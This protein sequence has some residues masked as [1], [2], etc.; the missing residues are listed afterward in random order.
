M[1]ALGV[2]AQRNEPVT[3]KA[4]EVDLAQFRMKVVGESNYQAA[5]IAIAG[6]PTYNGREL[7]V[8]AVL[9]LDDANPYDDQAVKVVINGRLVG[10]LSRAYAREFCRQRSLVGTERRFECK[11][12][13]RGGW[14]KSNGDV[15]MY[16]VCVELPVN[17][18]IVFGIEM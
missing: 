13:I 5:L 16:G 4:V 6:R 11:A 15:G 7:Y 12:V 8:D 1:K 14:D 3:A 2:G 17:R 18:N 9:E 10:Y